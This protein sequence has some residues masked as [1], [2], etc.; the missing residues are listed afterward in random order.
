MLPSDLTIAETVAALYDDHRWSEFASVNTTEGV[1]W[2][3]KIIDKAAIAVFRGSVTKLDFVKDFMAL[4]AMIID[5][6][7][8]VH[9]GFALGCA[10]AVI[11]LRNILPGDVD[12]IIC[13]HSL[14]AARAWIAAGL[15]I[16]N[17]MIPFRI[18]TFGSPRP[19]YAKLASIVSEVPQKSYRNL[20]DFVC[21]VP[22]TIHPT[23]PYVQPCVFTPLNVPPEPNDDWGPL[24]DHHFELYLKAIRGLVP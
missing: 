2:G 15:A 6:I 1:V 19:G 9:S 3:V 17:E 18:V 16:V 21:E 11:Q 14:G 8:P 20:H 4:P 23:F 12:L 24:A 22:F 10:P 5:D 13:G 7:G